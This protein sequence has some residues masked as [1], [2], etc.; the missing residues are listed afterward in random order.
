MHV[1]IVDDHPLMLHGVQEVVREAWP[2]AVCRGAGRADEALRLVA[3]GEPVDLACIDL[4]LPDLDGVEL[5]RRLRALRPSLPVIVLSASDLALQV[6]QALDAGAQIYLCKS[7]P[8]VELVAAL[9][10]Y[11]VTGHYVLPGVRDAL[12]R[13]RA[14]RAQRG[15]PRLT[16]RQ[17]DVLRLMALGL[18]NQAIG[19][20]LALSES[21]V[22]GH[23]SCLLDLLDAQNRTACVE[24]ARLLG[25]V[26]R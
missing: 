24:Q 7:L 2:E 9:R 11:R 19:A 17:L 25:L 20:R 1:L 21:T 4:S 8:R 23:V 16:Q 13:R 10:E 22:K 3:S 15:V 5:I 12:A 18:G 14:A 26:E 6:E